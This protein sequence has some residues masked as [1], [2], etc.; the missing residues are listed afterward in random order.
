MLKLAQYGKLWQHLVYSSPK[1]SL[2]LNITRFNTTWC[3]SYFSCDI[4]K[5]VEGAI[6]YPISC[7]K[8]LIKSL[9]Q[10]EV[11]KAFTEWHGCSCVLLFMIK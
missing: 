6:V 3:I 2:K 4:T 8:L 11:V 5:Y 7:R 9:R 10:I 1:L